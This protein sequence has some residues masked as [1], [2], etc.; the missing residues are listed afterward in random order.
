MTRW[1]H[2]KTLPCRSPRPGMTVVMAETLVALTAA[3]EPPAAAAPGV[4]TGKVATLEVSKTARPSARTRAPRPGRAEAAAGVLGVGVQAAWMWRKPMAGT[5]MG[6]TTGRKDVACR[7]RSVVSV[8]D[9][10]SGQ[11]DDSVNGG[12]GGVLGGDDGAATR[13]G[14]RGGQFQ[15]QKKKARRRDEAAS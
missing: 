11:C 1:W 10:W 15:N 2:T 6:M 7:R 9:T 8:A 3:A 5:T 13:S 4:T 14:T 12:D